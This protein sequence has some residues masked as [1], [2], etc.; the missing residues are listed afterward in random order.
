MTSAQERLEESQARIEIQ[1]KEVLGSQQRQGTPLLSNSLDAS[2]PEGHQTWMNLGRTL[3]EE[4][5]TPGMIKK[6]QNLL[7]RAMKDT[8]YRE[9]TLSDSF[10]ESY[11]TAFEYHVTGPDDEASR[12]SNSQNV[13]RL[14]LQPYSSPRGSVQM[15][16]SAPPSVATFSS[17]F[18]QRHVSSTDPL[19]QVENIAI[20]MNSLLQGMNGDKVEAHDYNDFIQAEELTDDDVIAM[21]QDVEGC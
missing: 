8:L 17:E 6:N 10:N 1:L 7:I 12:A 2:S 5:I 3:Q 20:G 13:N 15:L 19:D 4:G 18:L 11:Q 21:T 16:G 14:S 9:A